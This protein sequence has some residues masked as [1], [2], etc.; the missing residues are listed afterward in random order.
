MGM[1]G[2]T[3]R[4]KRVLVVGD[5]PFERDALVRELLYLGY[6][7]S[8][9]R[10]GPPALARVQHERPDLLILQY[11]VMIAADRTLTA[12]VREEE[13]LRDVRILNVA[14]GVPEHVVEDAVA[15][16]VDAIVQSSDPKRV[17]AEVKQLIGPAVSP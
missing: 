16:G 10:L 13:D 4:K 9:S 15:A 1:G 12:T 8:Q 5:L 17:I 3:Q 7:V 11:P 2:R 14:T 6:E